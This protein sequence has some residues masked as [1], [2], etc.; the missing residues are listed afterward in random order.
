MG[1][2]KLNLHVERKR[3]KAESRQR[4]DKMNGYPLIG[5]RCANIGGGAQ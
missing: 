4:T 1:R 2:N 5:P 3:D